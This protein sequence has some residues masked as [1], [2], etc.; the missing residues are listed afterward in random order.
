MA[1]AD[2]HVRAVQ[3]C[4][5]RVYLAC[6][7]THVRRTTSPAN[8]TTTSASLAGDTGAAERAR[9]VEELALLARAADTLPKRRRSGA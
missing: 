9:A 5:P 4:Y 3:A 7:V 8:I 6:H 2:R 1:V